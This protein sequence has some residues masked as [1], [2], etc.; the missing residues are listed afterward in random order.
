MYKK[1]DC[2]HTSDKTRE[3]LLPS[4]EKNGDRYIT[5]LVACPICARKY[6]GWG[7]VLKDDA[8][9]EKYLAKETSYMR[10]Y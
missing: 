4:M 7:V 8:A 2:G 1:E 6:K 5:S 3:I 9:C 10:L